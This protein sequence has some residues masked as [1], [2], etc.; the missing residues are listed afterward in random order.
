MPRGLRRQVSQLSS[1]SFKEDK[2][3]ASQFLDGDDGAEAHEYLEYGRRTLMPHGGRTLSE[4]GIQI[5]TPSN[6]LAPSGRRESLAPQ[7]PG[8]QWDAL[9]TW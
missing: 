7:V 3:G 9:K 5:W 8:C 1:L 2:Q 4:T 6:D